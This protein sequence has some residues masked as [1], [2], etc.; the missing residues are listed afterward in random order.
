MY[1]I[2]LDVNDDIY[3]KVMFFLDN[4]SEKDLKIKEIRNYNIQNNNNLVDFFR[5]SPMVGEVSV[6][7]KKEIYDNRVEF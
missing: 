3:D 1:S 4:I 2:S 6:E 7:R 5:S